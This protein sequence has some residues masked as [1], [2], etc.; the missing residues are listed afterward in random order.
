MT[1]VLH[2]L[3]SSNW[4]KYD[5]EIP[6]CWAVGNSI[7]VLYILILSHSHPQGYIH[8]LGSYASPKTHGGS[9]GQKLQLHTSHHC[10]ISNT[11]MQVWDFLFQ[12][13]EP[14]QVWWLCKLPILGDSGPAS[15]GPTSSHLLWDHA[16]SKAAAPVPHER[17][18]WEFTSSSTSD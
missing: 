6:S 18:G 7:S 13:T 15:M 12:A 11:M 2:S 16:P 9:I 4:L 1:I 5:S 3:F 17:A 8:G 10:I 14:L